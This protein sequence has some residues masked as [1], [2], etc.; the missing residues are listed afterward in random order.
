MESC[1][2]PLSTAPLAT[3]T[4]WSTRSVTVLGFTTCFE[5]YRRSSHATTRVWRPS[6]RW[7]PEICARTPTPRPNTKAATIQSRATKPVAVGISHT[8][9][10]TTTWVMQ[11]RRRL[12][13]QNTAVIPL[14]RKNRHRD[15]R[16][17][18]VCVHTETGVEFSRDTAGGT[19]FHVTHLVQKWNI[20]CCRKGQLCK[21]RRI[22]NEIPKSTFLLSG[23]LNVTGLFMGSWSVEWFITYFS[24]HWLIQNPPPTPPTTL[25]TC[26]WCLHGLLH[27]EPGGQ[28]ALLPRS[29]LP[30]L[31]TCLQTAS[32]ANGTPSGRA[33]S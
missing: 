5:V 32:G 19:S 4:Q 6:H 27:T 7:R 22:Q 30:D 18:W 33:A 31:A 20:C 3:L 25:V 24:C 17:C 21:F 9:H 13:G 14:T 29:Y 10:L 26:R 12:P 28:D 23:P 2:T 1:W 16:I 15:G 11:V 8:H